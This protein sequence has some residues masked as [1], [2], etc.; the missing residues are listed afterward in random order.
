MT[1]SATSQAGRR[2]RLPAEIRVEQILDAAL[3]AFSRHGYEA[4]RMADIAEGAGLSKGGLYAHFR[5]K[6][7]IFE[8][9]LGQRLLPT[10][11]SHRWLLEN[12]GSLEEV[13]EA[14]IDH[15]YDR[16]SDPGMI[17]TLKL[18][19]TEGRRVPHL[20][21]RWRREIIDASLA[22]QRDIF[23]AAVARG[24]LRPGPLT[25]EPGL[26]LAPALYAAIDRMLFDGKED[27]ELASWRS[28]HKRM[29]IEMLA[30][31]G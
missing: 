16:L 22:E 15:L 13:I 18:L 11:A 10:F 4:A 17:A 31:K 1:T 6:E 7:A 21:E 12:D 24:Q 3:D 29:L 27:A 9:L 20:V 2:C 8:A 26:L 19:L 30:A 23:R 25:D 5:S 14:F 28:A